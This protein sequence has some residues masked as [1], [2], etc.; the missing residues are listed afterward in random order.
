MYDECLREL[1]VSSLSI[2]RVREDMMTVFRYLKDYHREERIDLF[3]KAPKGRIRSN[4]W[5]IVKGN[6]S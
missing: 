3:S 5:E 1:G 2:K 6:P 4:G